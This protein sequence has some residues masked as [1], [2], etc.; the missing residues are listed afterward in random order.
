MLL[1]Q[2][3][4]DTT[5]HTYTRQWTYSV[6]VC[7]DYS[8]NRSFPCLSSYT[9][10]TPHSLRHNNIDIRTSNKPTLASK[11]LSER[12]SLMSL[13]WNKKLETIKLSEGGMSKA[14]SIR[15]LAPNQESSRE[16]QRKSPWRKLKVLL[17]W[18]HTLR[19]KNSLI[20][21][22]EKVLVVWIR[23][24]NQSQHSL[25]PK[26]NPVQGPKALHIS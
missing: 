20:V 5:N 3:F 13:T 6:H 10:A 17:Q 21:N 11:C 16:M 18:T 4:W 24:W 12:K 7:S 1:L 19:K 23:R 9:W 2:L 22:T 8:T 25:K 15:P 26:P 14:Q